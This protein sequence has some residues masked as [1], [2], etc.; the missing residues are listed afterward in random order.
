MIKCI[1]ETVYKDPFF[2]SSWFHFVV[3][4]KKLVYNN[5]FV[6]GNKKAETVI[7]DYRL[8]FSYNMEMHFCFAFQN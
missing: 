3:S 5:N 2:C 4:C 1:V 7:G 6:D 8:F